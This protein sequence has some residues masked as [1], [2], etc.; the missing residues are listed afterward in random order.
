MGAAELRAS[1][2]P[3]ILINWRCRFKLFAVFARARDIQPL[4]LRGGGACAGARRD[5]EAAEAAPPACRETHRDER[6]TDLAHFKDH[7]ITRQTTH[8]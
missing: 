8:V 5:P 2:P 7:L 6:L 3:N 4:L 1:A